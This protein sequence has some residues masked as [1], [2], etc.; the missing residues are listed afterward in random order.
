M[1]ESER[2]NARSDVCARPVGDVSEFLFERP[3]CRLVGERAEF[4]F[5]LR[6]G[7]IRHTQSD[8]RAFHDADGKAAG[9]PIWIFQPRAIATRL[10]TRGLSLWRSRKNAKGQPDSQRKRMKGKRRPRLE[11]DRC[12]S[13]LCEGFGLTAFRK[14]LI[15]F[16]QGWRRYTRPSIASDPGSDHSALCSCWISHLSPVFISVSDLR[17]DSLSLLER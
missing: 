15:S 1:D 3:R 7:R 2:L 4:R 6:D 9:R 16:T 11:L 13:L 5:V 17:L 10:P 14:S 8:G 12:R